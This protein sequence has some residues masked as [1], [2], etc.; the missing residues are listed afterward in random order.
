MLLTL[1]VLSQALHP[2][3]LLVVVY[4]GCWSARQAVCATDILQWA[5]DGALPFLSLRSLS[6]PVLEKADAPSLRFPASLL[7]PTGESCN[8]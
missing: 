7:Q 3:L 8:T 6:S 4:L 2:D 5:N 1:S